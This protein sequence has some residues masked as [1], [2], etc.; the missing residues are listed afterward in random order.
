VDD[1]QISGLILEDTSS[2]IL[3]SIGNGNTASN[4]SSLINFLHH[5]FF[6]R[7]VSILISVVDVIF[8][9]GEAGL[10]RHAVL[11]LDDFRALSTVIVSSGSVDGASLISDLVGV[12]PLEGIVGLSSVASIILRARDK[13]LRSNVDIRPGSLSGDLNSIGESRGGGMSP[14]GSA[15]L[16][17]VLV[18][19]VGKIGN[20][21]NVVPDVGL[22]EISNWLEGLSDVIILRLSR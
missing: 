7:D 19:N 2:V 21:I 11:A 18:S 4:G 6:S 16:G 12:H 22:G 9:G 20:S 14:A 1:V 5:S 8:I 17:N 15:I 13:N 3:K 10:S